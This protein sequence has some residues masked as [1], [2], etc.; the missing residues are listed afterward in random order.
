MLSLFQGFN[1]I[2]QHERFVLI[3]LNTEQYY[4]NLI[5]ATF[6]FAL[7]DNSGIVEF[8]QCYNYNRGQDR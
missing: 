1:L 3:D 2:T 7:L 8:A 5:G 4:S 6:E